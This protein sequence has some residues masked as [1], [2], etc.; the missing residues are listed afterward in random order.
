MAAQLCH[1]LVQFILLASL[2]GRR[3]LAYLH[4][5]ED[6]LFHFNKS[7]PATLTGGFFYS[8]SGLRVCHPELV[9]GCPFPYPPAAPFLLHVST[10]G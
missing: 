6:I 1:S 8:P 2:G 4:F 10:P 7:H 9:E 3:K 5:C